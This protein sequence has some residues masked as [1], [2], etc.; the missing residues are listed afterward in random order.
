MASEFKR[1]TKLAVLLVLLSITNVNGQLLQDT[2]IMN[3]VRKD[4]HYIYSMDFNNAREIYAK[5]VQAYPGHPIKYLLNAMITY[6]ENYPMLRTNRSHISYEADLRQCIKLSEANKNTYAEAEYLLANICAR[7][8]LLLF[9]TDNNLV[10]DVIPLATSTYKYLRRSFEYNSVCADLYYFTGVYNYYREAYPKIHPVYRSLAS[11]FPQGDMIRGL[12]ELKTC[13]NS[14]YVLRAES[15]FMLSWIYLNYENNYH[16]A[17]NYSRNLHE[18]YPENLQYLSLYLKDLLLIKQYDEAEKLISSSVTEAGNEFFQAQLNVL[19]GIV[20]EKKY[21]DNDLAGQFYYKGIQDLS[22][23][24]ACGDE[25]SA[26]AYFGL[27]RISES[28]GEKKTSR[29]YRKEAISLA[30]FK[31]I[32]F[33]K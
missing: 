8:L 17:L 19:K 24:G 26:Y 20:Q 13:A 1:I 22:F 12:N 2:A 9:Y 16:E 3:L 21:H 29:I 15:S 31:K 32:D 14:S 27:S 5:I 28:K 33:D 30:D 18:E 4:I 11:L 25:Y 10:A 6:W 7:G 23:F